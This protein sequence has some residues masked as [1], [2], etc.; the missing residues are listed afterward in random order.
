M[1]GKY[2]TQEKFIY[3]WG[4]LEKAV[5]PQPH[6]VIAVGAVRTRRQLW[7]FLGHTS[8]FRSE[9]TS[10]IAKEDILHGDQ[11]SAEV[12]GSGVHA[13]LCTNELSWQDKGTNTKQRIVSS[14]SVCSGVAVLSSIRREKD[15]VTSSD[16]SH[17]L[18]R[19]TFVVW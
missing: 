18:N 16:L 8:Q 5:A 19:Q 7:R 12:M 10:A 3:H 11:V 1:D 4:K 13:Y 15:M 9:A 2:V 17:S 6:K 14:E